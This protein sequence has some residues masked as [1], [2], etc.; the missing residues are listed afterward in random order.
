M[1]TNGGSPYNGT[2]SVRACVLEGKTCSTPRVHGCRVHAG[3]VTCLHGRSAGC[4]KC[5]AVFASVR[6][7]VHRVFRLRRRQGWE[8]G[9]NSDMHGSVRG[10][11][12]A[13][14]SDTWSEHFAA[15]RA[16]AHLCACPQSD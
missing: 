5:A 12:Q 1:E 8:S 6:A 7:R 9:G 15:A 10:S 13:C 11:H 16:G 3:L 2:S 14:A 4:E